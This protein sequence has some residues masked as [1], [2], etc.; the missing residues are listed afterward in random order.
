[1]S[2][3]KG[4]GSSCCRF[5]KKP[6]AE[7][8][9]TLKLAYPTRNMAHQN[10][11]TLRLMSDLREMQKDAPEVSV[12]HAPSTLRLTV[13]LSPCNSGM[14]AY[15]DCCVRLAGG[16]RSAARRGKHICLGSNNFRAVRHAVGRRN[17]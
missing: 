17:L 5:K 10:A 9:P 14:R 1:M 2:A 7:N 6:N 16:K 11:A 12:P 3:C 8:E 13:F 15:L 4:G